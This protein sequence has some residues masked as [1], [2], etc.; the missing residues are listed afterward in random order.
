VVTPNAAVPMPA[1]GPPHAQPRAPRNNEHIIEHLHIYLVLEI[2]TDDDDDDDATQMNAALLPFVTDTHH[3]LLRFVLLAGDAFSGYEGT[4]ETT[5][6]ILSMH[7]PP[8]LFPAEICAWFR[9]SLVSFSAWRHGTAT[10]Q[11]CDS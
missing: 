4:V 9:N 5:Y 8:L 3:S 2:H 1:G 10:A 11:P 6:S 7:N